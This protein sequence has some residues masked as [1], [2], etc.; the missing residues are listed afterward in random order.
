MNTRT[1]HNLSATWWFLLLVAAATRQSGAE[2]LIQSGESSAPKP[3][4]SATVSATCI[5]QCR[6]G[7]F[8]HQ[9]QCLEKCNPPCGSNLIC[10]DAGECVSPPSTPVGSAPVSNAAARAAQSPHAATSDLA[11]SSSKAAPPFA[12]PARAID[13]APAARMPT[14]SQTRPQSSRSGFYFQGG[15]GYSGL[16][17][18]SE[19]TGYYTG[20]TQ[21]SGGGLGVDFSL[22]GGLGS[23]FVLGAGLETLSASVKIEDHWRVTAS[24]WAS[25]NTTTGKQQVTMLAPNLFLQKFFGNFLLRASAGGL[26][27]VCEDVDDYDCSEGRL[28]VGGGAGYDFATS[29]P[30]SLGLLGGLRVSPQ[31][32]SMVISYS[33]KV[34]GT[35]Y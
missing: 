23:G 28:M 8:C 1:F 27:L 16:I 33:L 15:L 34:M 26:I 14:Q 9:G 30:W 10:S 29:G 12:A 19:Y 6:S 35:Y 20:D 11:A 4:A 17:R 3:D 24:E 25:V 5:P 7:Y 13:S 31:A 22:G 32:E 18:N 21:R 2:Q